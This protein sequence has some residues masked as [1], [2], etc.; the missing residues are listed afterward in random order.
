MNDLAK[1]PA[2]LALEILEQAFAYYDAP[3][4]SQSQQPEP[5]EY[6]E[7]CAAA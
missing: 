5:Q 1:T 3:P 6:F 7:Y 4:P 2:E